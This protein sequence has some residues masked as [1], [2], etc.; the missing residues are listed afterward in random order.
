MDTSWKPDVTWR[1]VPDFDWEGEDEEGGVVPDKDLEWRMD[2]PCWSIVDFFEM[3]K[4]N[5][6]R[7]EWL[8]VSTGKVLDARAWSQVA[9]GSP[10]EGMTE[11]LRGIFLKHGWPDLERYCKDQCLA[12]IRSQMRERFPRYVDMKEDW[13]QEAVEVTPPAL[14]E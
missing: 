8:P 5:Y 3:L 6:R 1:P 11:M 9:T 2:A 14:Q 12:E 13:D 7:L 4:D 10:A